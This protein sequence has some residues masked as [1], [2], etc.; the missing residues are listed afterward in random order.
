MAAPMLPALPPRRTLIENA[1]TLLIA[2]AGGLG[3]TY[4]GLP[5]GLVS[6]SVVAVAT[7][8]QRGRPVNLPLV[9]AHF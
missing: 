5:A 8:A 9:M 6:G 3:F 2:L 1:E 4:F 7:A